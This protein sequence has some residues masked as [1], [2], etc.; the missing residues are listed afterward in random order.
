MDGFQG[1]L[2]LPIAGEAVEKTEKSLRKHQKTIEKPERLAGVFLAP[3]GSA[4]VRNGGVN[5]VVTWAGLPA[6]AL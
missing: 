6:G 1:L 5:W 4:C 2:R 3:P